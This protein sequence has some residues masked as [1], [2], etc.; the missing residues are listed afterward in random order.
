MNN[1]ERVIWNSIVLY[2][3]IILCIVLSLWTIPIVLH[4]LGAED[5]GLYSLVAG[6][7]A[8]LSFI[9]TS[10]ASSTLRYFSVARGEGD[11]DKLRSYYNSSVTLHLIFGI[12]IVIILE[13]L[14]PFLFDH[15]L[16]IAPERIF[17]GKIIYQSLIASMFITIMTVPFD[18]ELNAYENMLVFAIV[19]ICDYVF[20]LLLAFSLQFVTCDKLIWYGLGLIIIPL[21]NIG[22]KYVYSHNKYKEFYLVRSLIWNPTI[23][24]EMLGFTSWNTIGAMAGVVRNQ[25]LAIMLNLMGGTVLNASYGIANQI[26]GVMGYF[27]QTLRKSLNPQLI[28]SEGN[29]DRPR[30]IR[31]VYTSS[32]FCVLVMGV[33]AIPL[34]V[35]LPLV[36]KMWLTNVPEYTLEFTTWI[37][38]V[39]LV[40]QM[41]AGLLAGVLA[42]GKIRNYQI[43]IT[44]IT[45]INLP[46]A[47]ILLRIGFEPYWIIVGML[48]CEIL[49]L[50]ARLIF[51][52]DLFGLRIRQFCWQ[53]ILPLLMILGLDWIILMGI[54]NVMDTSFIRLV[55]NSVLS[56]IIVGGLAW[57]FLLNQM[58]KNA[59]LQFVKRFTQKIKR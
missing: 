11:V 32:K 20:R 8:M 31:L 53:V 56:V 52:K 15:F 14:A 36:L 22:F 12:L 29:A 59:L 10:M 51:A 19:E 17:A 55:L 44:I 49:S 40:N 23:L 37:L 47:Y 42:V 43:I 39:S 35:E 48:A 41:S 16:N 54:T 50:V 2:A 24:R 46:I 45:L 21:F 57:L 30:M 18:A 1:S 27:S 6:V 34:I 58:E 7:I 38:L 9:R 4:E 26:N 25:G 33:I 5:Y 13:A 28:Q 3:K